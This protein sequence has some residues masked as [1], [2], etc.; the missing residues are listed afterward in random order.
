MVGLETPEVPENGDLEDG[1]CGKRMMGHF[2]VECGV[3]R[4]E[5]RFTERALSRDVGMIVT[6][7]PQWMTWRVMIWD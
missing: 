2:R 5:A 3:D 4:A 7:Y 1:R 6:G